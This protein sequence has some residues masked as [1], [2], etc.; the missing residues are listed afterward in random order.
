MFLN[1]VSAYLWGDELEDGKSR[2]TQNQKSISG[3]VPC[4]SKK[5][6]QIQMQHHKL[7]AQ[8]RKV[9]IE[10]WRENVRRSKQLRDGI[11]DKTREAEMEEKISKLQR[12]EN[13][14]M[15]ALSRQQ[16]LV[17]TPKNIRQEASSTPEKK[18]PGVVIMEVEESEDDY[19]MLVYEN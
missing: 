1:S 16:K 13:R 5:E 11:P 17:D 9:H 4:S 12:I 7:Q 14:C 15:K 8:M 18:N 2:S 19:V 10:M 6:S 3:K